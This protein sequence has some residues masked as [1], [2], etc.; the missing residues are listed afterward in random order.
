[1]VELQGNRAGPCNDPLGR[2]KYEHIGEVRKLRKIAVRVLDFLSASLLPYHV[3]GFALTA[4]LASTT[5]FNGCG[6]PAGGQHCRFEGGQQS[7]RRVAQCVRGSPQCR[8]DLCAAPKD[9]VSR[10]PGTDGSP[11]PAPQGGEHILADIANGYFGHG[12]DPQARCWCAMVAHEG[13][14]VTPTSSSHH[15]GLKPESRHRRQSCAPS[16]RWLKPA[17]IRAQ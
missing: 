9:G 1:M 5:T 4:T 7:R 15:W 8:R 17:A 13:R 11:L 16:A 2:A 12:H 14:R 10:P 3:G 6:P